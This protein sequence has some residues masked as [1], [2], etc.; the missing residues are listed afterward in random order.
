MI[1]YFR[2]DLIIA[3]VIGGCIP[4]VVMTAWSWVVGFN[5][6]G[7][8]YGLIAALLILFVSMYCCVRYATR[9]AD[10]KA[11]AMVD[12][13]DDQCDPNGFIEA[14]TPIADGITPPV[15]EPG[16]W[17]LSLFG[18]AS[19]DIGDQTRARTMLNIVETS[20][21]AAK[22]DATRSAILTNA[23]PLSLKLRGPEATA[24]L[25][26]GALAML[27]SS[28]DAHAMLQ[29]TYLASQRELCRDLIDRR[30]GALLARYRGIR[31][32]SRAVM[33][34]RVEY[35]WDEA[36]ICY[37]QGLRDEELDCL[38]FIVDHG[39]RL[40]FVPAAQRRLAELGG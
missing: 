36:R 7:T 27:E 31:E 10:A 32:D 11:Q 19:L 30:D 34:M 1:H 9:R 18:Q 14:A 23:I 17:F 29:K 8:L 12:V 38:R 15:L 24:T 4:L 20:A 33:R 16:A 26:D 40:A 6:S 35:A 5:V 25:I 37:D 39:N 22:N 21:Q 13:Y 28:H 3:V 2:R